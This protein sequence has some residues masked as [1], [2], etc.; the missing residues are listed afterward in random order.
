MD[1]RML[2]GFPEPDEE[3]F[4]ENS[5]F[6]QMYTKKLLNIPILKDPELFELIESAHEGNREAFDKAVWHNLRLAFWFALRYHYLP[7]SFEDLVQEAN[8]GLMKAVERFDTERGTRFSTYAAYWI[9]QSIFRAVQDTSDF[10]RLPVHM[11]ERIRKL[12]KAE[13][14]LYKKEGHNSIEESWGFCHV[15]RKELNATRTAMALDTISIYELPEDSPVLLS[16]PYSDYPVEEQAIQNITAEKLIAAIEMISD[17]ESE[18]RRL[19]LYFGFET[20]NPMSYAAVADIEGKSVERIRQTVVRALRRIRTR[21]LKAGEYYSLAYLAGYTDEKT[22]SEV[23]AYS[24]RKRE[25]YRKAN[26]IRIRVDLLA[27]ML[28]HVSMIADDSVLLR[29]LIAARH[30]KTSAR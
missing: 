24:E 7:L 11:Q 10:I 20:G 15:Y 13:D 14:E 8:I 23:E 5:H 26:S 30:E 22:I 29:A 25:Q 27:S 19:R 9:K 3:F 16:D 6:Y 28:R 1:L 2:E 4:R 18:Y 21:L 17:A 12:E